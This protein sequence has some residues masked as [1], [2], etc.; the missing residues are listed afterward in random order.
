MDDLLQVHDEV[1]VAQFLQ[2][3]DLADGSAWDAIV[4]VVNLNLLDS[5]D[6]VGAN[7]FG[8]VNDTIGAFSQ[9]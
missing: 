6:I 3:S 7:L 9:L 2:H 4:A 8:H 1:V 5:Y